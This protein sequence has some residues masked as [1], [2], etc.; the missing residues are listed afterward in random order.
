MMGLDMY[1]SAE[2]YLWNFR[3]EDLKI[4]KG[5]EDILGDL[6]DTKSWRESKIRSV[7][8]EVMYWRKVNAIHRWFVDKVQEGFDDC[9]QYPVSQEDLQDLVD[10]CQEVIDLYESDDPDKVKKIEIKL[11]TSSGFFFGSDEYDEYYI[12][13]LKRTV[14][15]LT[16]YL[17]HPIIDRCDFY[18]QSSW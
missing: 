7:T 15:E 6:P 13:E 4:A 11:P 18:Y 12:N 16:V 9:K 5:I 10:T 8:L 3:E 17:N 14:Q 1:L 2:I